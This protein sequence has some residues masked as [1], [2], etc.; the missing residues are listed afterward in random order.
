M[1][2][3]PEPTDR[4]EVTKLA[5]AVEEA[6]AD[7][8]PTRFRDE[9][10]DVPSWQDGSRIGAAPPVPQ[11]GIP[12]QSRGAV[13][14]AVRVLSTGVASVL[15]SGGASLVMVASG[16]ANPIVIGIVAGAPIAVAVPIAA[17][18]SLAKRAKEV[19]Q[20]APPVINNH[21]NGDVYQD[22]RKVENKNTGVW[23]RN[24]NRQ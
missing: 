13:D 4:A 12:P 15:V 18:G 10:P 3:Q 16:Y 2:P 7:A 20:A 24:T 19:V 23:V 6:L 21:Y 1:N 8:M 11:P 22:R 17:L 5:N 14:Y 9:N